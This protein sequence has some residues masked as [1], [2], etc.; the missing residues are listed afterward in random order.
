MRTF[1]TFAVPLELLLA[2]EGREDSGVP[3]VLQRIVEQLSQPAALTSPLLF[4]PPSDF[5]AIALL[6]RALVEGTHDCYF[7]S[8]NHLWELTNPD[9]GSAPPASVSPRD[10]SAV[11]LAFLSELPEPLIPR[12]QHERW[13]QG[14]DS[15]LPA[16]ITVRT[17]LFSTFFLSLSYASWLF[18]KTFLLPFSSF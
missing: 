17:P 10:L 7:G 14:K 2:A 13:A 9:L 6:R 4:Q 5:A 8:L 18:S 12:D 1:G 15:E 11:L 3:A 16:L